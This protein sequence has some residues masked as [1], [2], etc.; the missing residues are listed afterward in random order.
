MLS[1]A[2]KLRGSLQSDYDDSQDNY[3]D[4][5]E[6]INFLYEITLS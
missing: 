6:N 4:P 5:L 2:I 3:G 1:N